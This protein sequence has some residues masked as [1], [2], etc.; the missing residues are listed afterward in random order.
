[1]QQLQTQLQLLVQRRS[2]MLTLLS[3]LEGLFNQTSM[4]VI[5]N[6]R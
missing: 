4:Q 1:M 2:Q 5:S 3:N 6:I